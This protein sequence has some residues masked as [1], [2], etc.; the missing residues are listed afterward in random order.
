VWHTPLFAS[1][2]EHNGK[3]MVWPWK[4]KP[5]WQILQAHGVEFLTVGHVHRYERFPRMLADGTASDTGLRQ[6]IVGTGGA[7][8]MPIRTVHPLSE[9]Q[10]IARGMVRFDLYDDRYEW[11]FTDISGVQR[12]AGS[13]ACRLTTVS[14]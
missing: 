14:S 7:G 13:Q 1:I 6:F 11:S 4:L 10:V 9:R 8:L 2:C 12:D 3:A 5:L